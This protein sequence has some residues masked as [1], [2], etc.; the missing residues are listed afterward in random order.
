M[1]ERAQTWHAVADLDQ[2]FGS[3]SFSYYP[4]QTRRAVVLM[5]GQRDLSIDFSGV[6]A[7]HIED[8]C[9]G[10]FPHPS[11]L[12]LLRPGI[13]FP[14]MRIENSKWLVQWFMYQYLSHYFLVSSDDLLH[15]IANSSVIARWR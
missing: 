12:P 14:L 11:V 7:V 15:V 13:T 6:I 4:G 1:E 9:P 8:E 10:N 3:I 2:G 5:H